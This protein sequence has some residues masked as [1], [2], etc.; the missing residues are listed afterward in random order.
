MVR[1]TLSFTAHTDGPTHAQAGSRAGAVSDGE[2][3]RRMSEW[4][5]ADEADT[6][7]CSKAPSTLR[8]AVAPANHTIL[9]AKPPERYLMATPT[10]WILWLRFRYALIDR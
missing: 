8:P 4:I 5:G 7:S 1:W 2:A 3:T 10:P 9:L 6:R